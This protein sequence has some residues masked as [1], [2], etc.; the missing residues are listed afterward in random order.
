MTR[1]TAAEVIPML[2]RALNLC[3]TD[4]RVYDYLNE[5]QERLITQG[6]W[7]GTYARYRCQA[8]D[9]IL[10]WPREVASV[11]SLA[12][13]N[14]PVPMRSIFH[15][16]L[17]FGPGIQDDTSGTLEHF[18]RL[19]MPVFRQMTGAVSKVKV[20]NDLVI[21]NNTPVTILGRDDNG[22]WVRTLYNGDYIDG[23]VVLSS[24]AGTLSTKIYTQI[25][26]VK[27]GVTS[28]PI[29]L[30]ASNTV[31]GQQYEVSK[32]EHDETCPSYRASYVPYLQQIASL[33]NKITIDA[34]VKLDLIPARRAEDFLLINCKPA[35]KDM[36]CACKMAD[37][38][39]D[40]IRKTEVIARGIQLAKVSLEAEL[41]HYGNI[42]REVV[43]IQASGG[44]TNE[45][46]QSLV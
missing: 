16:F 22:N 17:D 33:D 29:L 14:S 32:L 20:Y 42:N 2:A 12:V 40:P 4:S 28:G 18:D 10:V 19:N 30:Y 11:I 26:A 1:L 7:W 34:N 3:E 39:P 9:G 44:P 43:S 31:T 13:C 21:D 41:R 8:T 36:A 15:E 38:D 46:L 37:E 35:L 23:E 5:A 27:K 45:P 6:A 24:Q 25:A